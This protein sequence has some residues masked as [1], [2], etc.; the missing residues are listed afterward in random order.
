MALEEKVIDLDLNPIQKTKIRI[1]GDQTRII[2]LN[3]S[4]M[5]I[6]DRFTTASKNLHKLADEVSGL[7]EVVIKEGEDNEDALN[8]ISSKLHEL[9]Q[10][11]RKEIDFLFDSP[12]SDV[13]VPDGTMYDPHD[14]QFTFEYVIEALVKLYADTVKDEFAKVKKPRGRPA[15]RL[16]AASASSCG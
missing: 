12:V 7:S 15:S 11:M 9:D 5:G 8:D 3:L 6:I 4:D 13:C 1:G 14:G 16:A 10:K 2:E